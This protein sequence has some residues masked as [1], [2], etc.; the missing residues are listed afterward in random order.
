MFSFCL[1][2]ILFY[3]FHSVLA[4]S[5]TKRL[6]D[7]FI[8]ARWYRIF[9]NLLSILALAIVVWLYVKSPSDV[10]L[11]NGLLTWVAG[12]IFL[13][14]GVIVGYKASMQYSMREFSGVSYAQ[15]DPKAGNQLNTEGING[16]VRHPL[17]L[18]LLLLLATWFCFQPQWRVLAV[19][20]ITLLYVPVGIHFEEKKLI[21]AFGEEYKSYK[22]RVAM[23]I[24]GIW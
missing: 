19:F 21:A 22:R 12:G 20:V 16:I 17:Y 18:S 3:A 8:G 4:A 6:L 24:P 10:V 23:L 2:L 7:A 1:S 11:E 14:L 13:L 15:G 5:K 9:F